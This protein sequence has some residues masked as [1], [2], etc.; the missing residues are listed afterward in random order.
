[1]FN[2][3]KSRR[4]KKAGFTLIE[5]LVVILILGI[6]IAVA[7][8]LYLNSVRNAADRV[9]RANMKT[10][11]QSAQSFRVRT[12]AYPAAL[13]D[14]S[15]AQGDLEQPVA[16]FGPTGVAYTATGTATTYVVTATETGDRFGTS[17]PDETITY[18]LQT[19]QYTPAN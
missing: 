12:S 5:L 11:A 10:I 13:T 7:I 2:N 15:G 14:L 16:N 17:A 18:N 9:T 1:M 8:P 6:L 3:L 19:G 4:N